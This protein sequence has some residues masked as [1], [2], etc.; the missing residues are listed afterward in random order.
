MTDDFS[1]QPRTLLLALIAGMK[2]MKMMAPKRFK[3]W[4]GVAQGLAEFLWAA[5]N[6]IATGVR[7]IFQADG[8]RESMEH[9]ARCY[10]EFL[11]FTDGLGEDNTAPYEMAEDKK[12][13]DSMGTEDHGLGVRSP[14]ETRDEEANQQGG[15]G[16]AQSAQPV[17]MDDPADR[18]GMEEH[19]ASGNTPRL[20]SSTRPS[21]DTSAHWNPTPG[22]TGWSPR[23]GYSVTGRVPCVHESAGV[24]RYI[25]ERVRSGEQE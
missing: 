19:A 21:G 5:E 14:P 9:T 22:T 23:L 11:E 7:T 15:G 6:D 4:K 2:K 8:N 16:P 10:S 12:E 20:C 17:D 24:S 25:V 3:E 18:D 13:G 1:N